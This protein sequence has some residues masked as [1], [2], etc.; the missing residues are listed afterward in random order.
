M[1]S[2]LKRIAICGSLDF[3][4]EIKELADDLTKAGF[5]V[6]IPLTS[7]RILNGETTVEQIKAEKANGTFADRAI[8][9]DSIREYWPVIRKA[10][11]I[12]VAN[13]DK[14]GIRSY[15]GGNTFLEMG[16]AHVL[17]KPIFLLQGIPQLT[18]TDEIR[19]MQPAQLEGRLG[20]LVEFSRS[21]P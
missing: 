14:K 18:Y 19:A 13:Y 9:F 4:P 8:K 6:D 5:N 11:A 17:R 16:F 21:Q 15:I 12:L 2:E 20:N 10:D 7:R 1:Q 3:T